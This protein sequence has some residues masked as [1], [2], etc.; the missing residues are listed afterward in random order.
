M[1]ETQTVAE[2]LPGT[3]DERRRAMLA[4]A[5]A[6]FLEHGYGR[7][8][9]S[10]VA[11]RIGGSKTTLWT[12]FPSKEALFL[13]VASDLI[14]EYAGHIADKLTF[15]GPF[16]Q[17]LR[18]FGCNLLASLTSPPVTALMRIVAAEAVAIPGLGIRFHEQGLAHGWQTVAA[19]MAEARARGLVHSDADPLRAAQHLI[20]LLQSGSYQRHLMSDSGSPPPDVIKADVAAAVA[21]FCRAYGTEAPAA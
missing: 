21:A 13:A 17:C 18:N 7:T 20:G 1:G 14:D 8:S 15:D 12:Y 16:D 5:R 9:M 4:V 10:A 3:S 2:A 19:Y 6:L 11:A